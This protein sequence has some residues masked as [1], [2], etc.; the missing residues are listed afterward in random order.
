MS[1]I[2]GI[3]SFI[4][5]SIQIES[6]YKMMNTCNKY[7]GN[8]TDYI[9]HGH[10]FFCCRH[11]AVTPEML[12]E[13]LPYRDPKTNISITADAVIYNRYELFHT[14]NINSSDSCCVTDCQ[15]ILMAYFKW[16]SDCTKF[17]I[18]DYAFAI[19][20]EN[21]QEAFI[22]RDHCG[23]R[24]LYYSVCDN[25][26]I[27]STSMEPLFEFNGVTRQ[28]DEEWISAYLS[29]PGPVHEFYCNKT[30]YKNVMQ[31]LPAHTMK[32]KDGKMN[33]ER[34]WSPFDPNRPKIRLKSDEEYEEAFREV[35][36][37]AVDCRLRTTGSVGV[38]LSGGLDSGSVA[39][40]AASKLLR[41]GKKLYAYC[42]VPFSGYKNLMSKGLIADESE[43]VN[44][45][46]DNIGNIDLSYIRA[47]GKT[48]INN[49]DQLLEVFE[50]PYKIIENGFWT[51]EIMSEAAKNGCTVLLN[52]QN[53]NSTISYG[54]I[55]SYAYTLMKHGRLISATRELIAYS[56][57]NKKQLHPIIKWFLMGIVP[58]NL[59]ELYYKIRKTKPPYL[60][61]IPVNPQLAS[62]C[63]TKEILK[64]QKLTTAPKIVDISEERLFEC[65]PRFFTQA[66]M[67]ETMYSLNYGIQVRDPT[68]DKRVI[69]FCY[70]IPDSQYVR[71]GHERYLLRRALEGILPDMVRLNY[72][73]RGYQGA[74]WLQRMIPDLEEFK[75]ELREMLSDEL[76]NSFLN[77]SLVSSVLDEI[78]N[79]P[80][81]KSLQDIRMLIICYILG[82]FIK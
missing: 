70:S 33:I 2:C 14:F 63:N 6:G 21:S 67:F 46:V 12:Q 77:V 80:R 39:S 28:L 78:S 60:L 16:G 58:E 34:Y 56:K 7:S 45:L 18:G 11:N 69:E 54:S 35:F 36:F 55:F 42:S 37:N 31:L 59:L 71:N 13:K 8:Y 4:N 62:M 29:M 81:N 66:G 27:F 51:N 25:Q 41:Q 53:G 82:K 23:K 76:L 17:I 22:A 19:Y 57:I 52:G 10:Y 74:D 32:I 9:I 47:E 24:T 49:V 15:L 61:N 73:E 48:P 50:Q 65:H 20:D 64:K 43:Y 1:A 26:L 3:I 79:P 40:V 68:A 44:N 72:T 5:D 30:V 38:M 75:N